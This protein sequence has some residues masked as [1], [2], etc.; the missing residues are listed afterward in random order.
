MSMAGFK[1][2]PETKGKLSRIKLAYY[3][4]HPENKKKLVG[5]NNPMFG[6]RGALNPMFG[7][8]LSEE[9]KAQLS[10]SRLGKYREA[11][12]PFFGRHHSEETKKRM[13]EKWKGRAFPEKDNRLELKFQQ[14]LVNINLQSKKHAKVLGRPDIFI[15]PNICIFIDGCYWHG[16]PCKFDQA[17]TGQHATYIKSRMQH[18]LEVNKKLSD[19]GFVVLRF[20]EHEIN[21]EPSKFMQRLASSINNEEFK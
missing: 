1:H 7:K 19:N 14:E 16:C 11:E 9:A 15:E 3:K 5:E 17:Q 10:R 8:H 12:N 13:K 2:S 6:R 18:D 21:E 4:E 20:W